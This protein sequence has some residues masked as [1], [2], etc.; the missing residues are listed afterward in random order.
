MSY[1]KSIKNIFDNK[2]LRTIMLLFLIGLPLMISDT[3]I[4]LFI[5]WGINI[6]LAQSINVLSGF[7]GQISLGHAAFYGIGAYFTA[8]AMIEFNLSLIIIIPLAFLVNCF[9]GFLLSIPA[10]R[11]SE[12]YLA[13]MTLGFGF[14]VNEIF[15]EWSS[16]TGGVMGLSGIP[17]P[18]LGT[19]SILGININLTGYYWLV[20]LL[21]FILLWMTGNFAKSFVG[22]S[23]LAVHQSE[24]SA[25]SIGISTGNTKKLAYTLSAG[26]AGVAGALY[27]PFMGYIGPGTFEMMKSIEILVMG[28]LGGFG[29]VIGPVLGAGFLTYISN[30]LHVFKEYQMMV[31]ALL[32]VVSFIIIPKGFAGLLKIRTKLYKD[33]SSLI[34]SSN[35][36]D[37]QSNTR[38][39]NLQ[40]TDEPLL[41]IIDIEKNFSGLKA[42]DKVSLNLYKGEIV[43]LIGPNGS[44]KS[45]LVNLISGIYSVSSGKILFK[46][47][48]ISN[49]QCHLVA[50]QGIIRTFQDP[51]NVATMTVEENL[52]LGKHRMYTT[53]VFKSVLNSKRSIREEREIMVLVKGIINLANLN[54]YKGKQIEYLPYGIQ[55]IVEVARAI[56]NNPEVL[57]LDEPAAGLSETELETLIKL[58]NYAKNNGVS[59]ILIDHHMDFINQLADRVVVLDSGKEIYS[60]SV[61]EMQ[62]NDR[63]IEAYLGV[64][65][66]A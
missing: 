55:R 28:I 41:S 59:I 45:T 2:I 10:G 50:R 40:K 1:I 42:L 11:V 22:R 17:S 44:G 32:L 33:Y 15:K 35:I 18:Q 12:F 64:E 16:V 58:I 62:R 56:L 5:L 49:Y 63:V 37:T 4:Q 8:L 31:Y 38:A 21:V 6:L 14:I 34:D 54:Q 65:N 53:G 24:L 26:I 46:G 47:K 51:Q 13:M 36:S 27:A 29:T 7:A 19:L 61:E 48:D 25:S 60:G 39:S 52:L 66:N 43:G 23:F 57:L 30:E 20:L 9:F 3:Y